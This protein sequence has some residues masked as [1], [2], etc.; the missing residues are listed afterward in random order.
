MGR[1]VA[2]EARKIAAEIT[3]ATR[4]PVIRIKTAGAKAP[5]PVTASK[6]GGAPY[7]PVGAQAPTNESGKPLGMIAQINCAELPKNELY[8]KTGILQFWIDSGEEEGDENWGFNANDIANQANIRVIY[9]PQVGEATPAGTPQSPQHG[10]KTG[11]STR[12]RLSLR[13]LLRKNMRA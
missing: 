13:S 8:P 6:F 2:K 7:L 4:Q 1:T 10:A 12:Q 11:L 3:A 9:Y 5:L